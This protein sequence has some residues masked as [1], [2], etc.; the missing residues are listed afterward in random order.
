MIAIAR[1]PVEATPARMGPLAKL[2]IFL[3]LNGLMVVVAG[4]TAGAAWKAELAAAA[5]ATVNVYAPEPEHDMQQLASSR[6]DVFIHRREWAPDIFAGCA[7]AIADAHDD[8]EAAAFAA[9]ARAAGVIVNVIDRPAFCQVQFGS[10]VNRSPVVIGIST[11][12]AAPILGQTIR[13]RIETLLPPALA[14]WAGFAAAIRSHVSEALL[15]GAQRRRFWESFSRRAFGPLPSSS[16]DDAMMGLVREIAEGHDSS[17]GS[18]TLVGAGPGDAELLTL[19]AVRALQAADIILF[20]DLVSAD[21][22]ELA[23]REAKRMMV[24]KRGGRESCRQSDINELM[25]SLARSGK[26]VVRLKSGDPMLFGRAGEEIEQ[27]EAAGIP[28]HVVPG[29][30]SGV[31]LAAELRTSLTHRDCAQSVRFVTGH[32][33]AGGLPPELD[34][35]SLADPAATHVFYMGGRNAGAIVSRL[36]AEGADPRTP[37]VAAASLTRPDQALW[38]G[39]LRDLPAAIETFGHERPVLLGVGRALAGSALPAMRE[40]DVWESQR[41]RN[42]L[43]G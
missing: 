15:P 11:D 21:V 2:P 28:V 23:R 5:G 40:C 41:Q 33:R 37:A 12:G 35:R 18:V 27:L 32:S 34:W 38:R 14:Q 29:I 19:K 25:V 6:D 39:E 13:R 16:D 7:F 1:K 3:D 22:L 20:D 8:H 36:I 30:T 10:I 24:G 42:P 26:N 17:S 43:A 31:A 9:A 4:G